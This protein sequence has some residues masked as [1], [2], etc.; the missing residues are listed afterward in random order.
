MAWSD[1][2]CKRWWGDVCDVIKTILR[3]EKVCLVLSV[4][5]EFNEEVGNGKLGT[6]V[7]VDDRFFIAC[8]FQYLFL[9][10]ICFYSTLK[11]TLYLH[12]R[13]IFSEPEQN[14]LP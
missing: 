14:A 8:F 7:S 1:H 10:Q 2:Q 4:C 3:K 12:M 6:V 13:V 5:A 9:T 11:E